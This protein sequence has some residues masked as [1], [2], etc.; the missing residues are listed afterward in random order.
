MERGT[1]SVYEHPWVAEQIDRAKTMSQCAEIDY[2]RRVLFK[3]PSCPEINDFRVRCQ[4]RY[5][6]LHVDNVERARLLVIGYGA[7]SKSLILLNEGVL[8]THKFPRCRTGVAR[9]SI[10]IAR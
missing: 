6:T 5:S 7:R 9:L 4:S 3:T 8:T 2:G 1:Q 10:A